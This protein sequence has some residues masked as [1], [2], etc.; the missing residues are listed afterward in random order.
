MPISAIEVLQKISPIPLTSE[1]KAEKELSDRERKIGVELANRLHDGEIEYWE[2]REEIAKLAVGE[3]V[4][5]EKTLIN[6][7]NNYMDLLGIQGGL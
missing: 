5:Q 4:R 2:M 3:E 7:E 1:A 6:V